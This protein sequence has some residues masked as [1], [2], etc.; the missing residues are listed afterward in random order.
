MV[1]NVVEALRAQIALLADVPFKGGAYR[2]GWQA[3][4]KDAL[5]RIDYYAAAPAHSEPD[6]EAVEARW[7]LAEAIRQW[8]VLAGRNPA[9]GS[10]DQ[11]QPSWLL[12]HLAARGYRLVRASVSEP[13]LDKQEVFQQTESYADALE[14]AWATWAKGY[15]AGSEHSEADRGAGL[16]IERLGLSDE[17]TL[18]LHDHLA[19][20]QQTLPEWLGDV[21]MHMGLGRATGRNYAPPAALAAS[22]S[23]EP[24]NAD[25]ATQP[26]EREEAGE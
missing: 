9:T 12:N 18:L 7:E 26:A 17:Q 24:A 4:I 10:Y 20:R 11:P 22:Q 3:A 19:S 5:Y 21:L 1:T 6:A 23:P 2:D 8:Y 25:S 15:K 13:A 14:Y 16:A